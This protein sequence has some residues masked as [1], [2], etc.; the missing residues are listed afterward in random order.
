MTGDLIDIPLILRAAGMVPRAAELLRGELRSW[1]YEDD[2]HED[3]LVY[4]CDV[5]EAEAN[6]DFM[7]IEHDPE[8]RL[9]AVTAWLREWAESGMKEEAR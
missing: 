2:S 9:L 3:Y 8:C 6:D 1:C 7:A 5:C 4:R